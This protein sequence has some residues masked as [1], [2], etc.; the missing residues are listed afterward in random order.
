MAHGGSG[1]SHLEDLQKLSGCGPGHRAVHVPAPLDQMD[2]EVPANLN[3]SV[4]L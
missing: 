2:P 4:V 3:H 1:E